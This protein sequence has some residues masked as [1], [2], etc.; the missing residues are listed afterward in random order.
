MMGVLRRVAPDGA[1]LGDMQL[2]CSGAGEAR[3]GAHAT[4][5]A[6][7]PRAAHLALAALAALTALTALTALAA[8]SASAPCAKLAA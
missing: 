4:R 2:T 5:A 6:S 3:S 7:P 8:R 1:G